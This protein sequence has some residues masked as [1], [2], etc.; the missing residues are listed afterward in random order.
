MLRR[1][2]RSQAWDS[3]LA[4]RQLAVLRCPSHFTSLC[5][6]LI[7]CKMGVQTLHPVSWGCCKA[8]LKRV[9]ENAEGS[10]QVCA[11]RG[12]RGSSGPGRR[13]TRPRLQVKG[14]THCPPATP[15][16]K[17]KTPPSMAPPRHLPLV[18]N[19]NNPLSGSNYGP[20]EGKGFLPEDVIMSG[21]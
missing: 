6:N 13:L 8:E 3:T 20:Q 21:K 4:L 10:A 1:G 9:V 7:F 15:A 2:C 17:F 12:I 14:R 18:I 11:P 5:L 16:L 19:T